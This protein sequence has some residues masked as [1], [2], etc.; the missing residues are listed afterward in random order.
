MSG[1]GFRVYSR[2]LVLLAIL[3]FAAVAPAL[4]QSIEEFS[5][6]RTSGPIADFGSGTP[7]P[8]GSP[9]QTPAGNYHP[10]EVRLRVPVGYPLLADLNR[11]EGKVIIRFYIDENG[12]VTR[13]AIAS[14]GTNVLLE[15]LLGDPRLMKWTF[16]PATL[17]GTPV[18]STH[19]QEFEFRLDPEQQKKIAL[20][21]LALP[22]GTPDPPYPP[23]AA[24]DHLEGKPTVQ[25]QWTKQGLVDRIALVK[26]SGAPYLDA[27]ALRF[28]Y[29]NWRIDPAAVK[30]DQ[31]FVKTVSF[32]PAR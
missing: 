10:A 21:R 3:P 11:I 18:P 1:A 30:A 16:Q 28:V 24:A 27:S 6:V 12:H 7:A 29:E 4:A 17:N 32:V 31:P 14:R 9:A 13:T 2:C 8:A 5:E 15:Q 25:V 20:H 23:A 26:S 19:D 22:I